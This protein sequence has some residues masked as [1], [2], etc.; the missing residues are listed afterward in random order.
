MKA[1]VTPILFGNFVGAP[2]GNNNAEK[3]K[4]SEQRAE[5]LDAYVKHC[6]KG[7]ADESFRHNRAGI[8]T[9]KYYVQTYP[10]DFPSDVIE[11]AHNARFAFWET[12]GL[13]GLVGKP[14]YYTDPNGA[15]NPDD[16]RKP[17]KVRGGGFNSPAWQFNMQN[18][19]GWKLKTDVTTD[20]KPLR[21]MVVMDK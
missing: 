9:F 20:D 2:L 3:F 15:K 21:P 8:K 18:R 4:T 17:L 6:E 5:F 14:V 1:N 12:I 16:K 7:R 13:N 19:F 11:D 10:I